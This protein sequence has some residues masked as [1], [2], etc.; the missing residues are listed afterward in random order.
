MQQERL[1][2]DLAIRE[3]DWE[4]EDPIPLLEFF[5]R[6]SDCVKLIGNDVIL[7][8][9]FED[10]DVYIEQE[11]M[12]KVASFEFLRKYD[13]KLYQL[14]WKLRE[15]HIKDILHHR[16]QIKHELFFVKN[17]VEEEGEFVEQFQNWLEKCYGYRN[18]TLLRLCKQ[19]W[20]ETGLSD[21]LVDAFVDTL[22]LNQFKTTVEQEEDIPKK[23]ATIHKFVS[24]VQRN[25]MRFNSP[26]ED[27][28]DPEI[29]MVRNVV[30]AS[31]SKTEKGIDD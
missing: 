8:F 29:T 25:K 17:Q 23:S 31:T 30:N 20:H 15:V 26:G 9:D 4:G 10:Q 1:S 5:D 19:Y 2:D 14:Y 21:Y 16:N 6:S 27:A 3:I 12:I 22:K 13:Q 28:A 11:D 18:K 7:I 24:G